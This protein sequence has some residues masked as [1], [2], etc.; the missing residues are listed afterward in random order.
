MKK[1]HKP[2]PLDPAPNEL[3]QFLL[4]YPLRKPD[5]CWIAEKEP[6]N[7]GYCYFSFRGI[8][9]AAHRLAYAWH[10]NVDPGD[11]LVCHTC[12]TPSCGN[13]AHFFLG[14]SAD[15][16]NDAKC[17]G[18]L[19]KGSKSGT[20]KL[21]E[22]DVAQIRRLLLESK[23]TQSE[24][25][26]MYNVCP[27]T[28]SAI[29]HVGWQHV[30]KPDIARKPLN[31]GEQHHL[32]KL[33]EA[34]VRQIRQELAESQLTMTEIG[35]KYGV[36]QTKISHIARGIAWKQVN[37]YPV[38]RARVERPL[39]GD[40]HPLA[41]LTNEQVVAI[42]EQYATGE[43]T[44]AELAKAFGVTSGAIGSIVRGENWA[45]LPL[46][47]HPG[48]GKTKYR[49]EKHSNAKLTKAQVLEI[50]RR[51]LSG[52]NYGTI[53]AEFNIARSTVCGIKTGKRWSD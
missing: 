12:D 45:N 24:I 35:I 32:A 18:R 27:S 48:R 52:E 17:K 29:L 31:K 30:P 6:G 46:S 4:L 1:N 39:I 38:D 42:R 51:A 8:S 13:P 25:G 5:S 34:D 10:F 28:I 37:P 49:G 15:N 33:T 19:A 16:T 26:E 20:A 40:R 36:S 44:Q 43:S 21:T 11:F 22:N 2:I 23:L 3:K 41:I 9:Y 50:K 53:A 14:T 47:S 7:G